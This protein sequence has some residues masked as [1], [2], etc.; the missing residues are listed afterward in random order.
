LFIRA[1]LVSSLGSWRNFYGVVRVRA[2]DEPGSQTYSYGLIHGITIHGRQFLE[3]DKRDLPTAYFGPQSGIGLAILDFPKRDRGMRV[4][5]LGLGI[6]TISAYGQPGDVYRFY[7]INPAVIQLAQGE[8][9][10]FSYLKD[11]RAKVEVVLGD[12]RV[13][14]EQELASGHPQQYDVLA[15]DVFSSDAIPVHLLDEQSFDLYLKHLQPDGVLAVHITNSYLDL[16]PVVWTLADHFDLSR[17]LIR[18][19]GNPPYTF[20]S[21]W[22]LLARDPQLLETPTIQNSASS[23]D[24]YTTHLR[25]WTDDFSNLFQILKH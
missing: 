5:V 14:L 15:L 6:G 3:A 12:A 22:M 18:N 13:S 2:F 11:S 25:L 1:D 23:M 21:I 8:G 10:Y 4:G 19:P 24:G 20:P 17:V 7:E 9:G 16:V